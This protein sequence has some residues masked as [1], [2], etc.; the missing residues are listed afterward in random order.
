MD[1]AKALGAA[2]TRVRVVS[3]PCWELFEAKD[4]AYQL[5]GEICFSSHSKVVP[6]CAM[7]AYIYLP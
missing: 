6:V 1:V 5:S 2:G 3:M 4:K 7:H